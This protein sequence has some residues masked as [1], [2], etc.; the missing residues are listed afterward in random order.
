MTQ[1]PHPE[2]LEPPHRPADDTEQVYFHGTPV[3]RGAL[4][5]LFICVVIGLAM[6]GLVIAQWIMDWHF[7]W[8]LNLLLVL[9]GIAVVFIPWVMS[10]TVKY[11]ITNY[12]IDFERGI[13][14]KRIDTLEL[15]HV[16]DIRFHQSMFDRILKVGT[17]TIYSGDDTTP[18]LPMY[19]VP[20]PR[21]IFDLLKQRII[22]VKRQRGVIKFDGGGAGL[23]GD[24]QFE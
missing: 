9:G 2:P 10:K 13:L 19:G 12:R 6:I 5:R 4:G 22:A 20:N 14:S 24:P 17:I 11:R 8:W 21:P 18:Q 7:P 23:H 16:Q 3:L 15:W 1:A